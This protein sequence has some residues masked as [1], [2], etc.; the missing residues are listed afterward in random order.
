MTY[1]IIWEPGATNSAVR[2][3]KDDPVGL[4]AL[5]EA[6]DSL[7]ENPRPANSTAYGPTTRRLRVGDYR[8]LYFI[9]EAVIH[10]LVTHLGRTP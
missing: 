1:Q 3:L 7:S 10:I 9:D 8:A 2:F 5:Y 6:V 4:A